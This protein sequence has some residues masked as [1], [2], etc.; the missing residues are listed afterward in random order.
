M[1]GP[2]QFVRPAKDD[3]AQVHRAYT[4]AANVRDPEV[5]VLSLEDLGV[6]REVGRGADGEIVV[7]L[8]PTYS[9]CPAMHT[10]SEDVMTALEQAGLTPA[11]VEL[12]LSPAWTTDWMSDAGKAKLKAYGIAP[13]VGKAKRRGLFEQESVPCPRCDGTDTVKISEF[14]STSCKAQWRCQ[15]CKEPFDYFKCL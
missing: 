10:M 1:V 9:G 5:P 6:L 2:V 11:R 12:V 4:A 8:T 3:D 15:A 13:P 7:R 14:G